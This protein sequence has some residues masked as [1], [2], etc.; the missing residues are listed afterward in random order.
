MP[1]RVGHHAFVFA[2]GLHV[3]RD[4]LHPYS[5]LRKEVCKP[6]SPC[7]TA[8]LPRDKQNLSSLSHFSSKPAAKRWSK[9]EIGFMIV[10]RAVVLS[11][12]KDVRPYALPKNVVRFL[13]V[14]ISFIPY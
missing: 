7:E 8:R 2:K 12:S 3:R 4:A 1:R 14:S 10:W 13:F 9:V 11:G 5:K 6:V